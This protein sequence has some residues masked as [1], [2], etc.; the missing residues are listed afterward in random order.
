VTLNISTTLIY[1]HTGVIVYMSHT[2]PPH[3]ASM[4]DSFAIKS[5]TVH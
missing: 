1:I 4:I 2:I 3:R 5:K